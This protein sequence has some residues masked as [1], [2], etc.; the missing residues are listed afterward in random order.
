MLRYTI[1]N[2]VSPH[3]DNLDETVE[4]ETNLS[5]ESNACANVLPEHEK[6]KFFLVYRGKPTE[7]LAKSFKKLNAPCKVIMTTKKLKQALPSLKPSV[8]KMLRRKVVYKI[9]CPGC[10]SSYVG[11]TVRHVQRRLGE[12]LGSKGLLKTHFESCNV[13]NTDDSILPILDRSNSPSHLLTLE[14]LHINE[15][16]PN[17][18]TKDEYRSRTLT[19][20]LY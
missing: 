11:Q 1:S 2:L 16:K 14:A 6:Y 3:H 9:E 20:K 15:I 12:H 17:L 18:N 10:E 7:N 19:L 8:P 5:F 4:A 13:D